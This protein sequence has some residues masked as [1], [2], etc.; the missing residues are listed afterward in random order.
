MKIIKRPSQSTQLSKKK[1]VQV[2]SRWRS[3]KSN[4][5]TMKRRP[6]L[7]SKAKTKSARVLKMEEDPNIVWGKNKPLEKFWR[8]L[9]SGKKV[10]LIKKNGDYTIFTMPT[11]NMK[12]SKMFNSF[13]DDE[14]IISVLSSPMSQDSYEVYLYPKAKDKSVEYV[15][16]NYKKFFKSAG[17]TP[18]DMINNGFPAQK[19]VL[20]P[21]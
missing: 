11:D 13:D 5:K 15:I 16:E 20:F 21:A 2:V 18:K 17:P 7:K 1:I 4:L 12:I 10:V 9:A 8:E 14:N 19:K 6:K 3:A